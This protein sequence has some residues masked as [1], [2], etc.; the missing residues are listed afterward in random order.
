MQILLYHP[1]ISVESSCEAMSWWCQ[2]GRKISWEKPMNLQ[3]CHV[4]WLINQMYTI[5][6]QFY[7]LCPVKSTWSSYWL[8]RTLPDVWKRCI[9][10][11]LWFQCR[12]VS[13]GLWETKVYIHLGIIYCSQ[14]ILH[15]QC[16]VAI[17]FSDSANILE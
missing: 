15:L 8:G 16:W 4:K 3:K 7:V 10:L 14:C 9:N 11:Q 1:Q 6:G 12:S 2:N 5:D 17:H 13:N